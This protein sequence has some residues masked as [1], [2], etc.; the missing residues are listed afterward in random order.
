MRRDTGHELSSKERRDALSSG[1]KLEWWTIGAMATIVVAMYL[2][3]GSSQAMKA[4]WVEDL[5]GFVPPIAFLIANRYAQRDPNERF[6]YGYHRVIDI[7]FL[8][9]AVALTALG[10]YIFIDSVLGLIK[11]EHPTIGT[12]VIFGHQFWSGWL[13]IAVLVYSIIPPVILGRLKMRPARKI[14]DKT[15]K[16][17][18]DMNKADC[19]TGLAGIAGIIGIGV[20]WWWA[21]SVAAAVI[22]IDV[23]KDGVRNLKRVVSDVM[24][25]RPTTVDGE[26]SD[27]PDRVRD[28]LLELPW[29]ADAM[30]RL[31]EEGHIF[32]GE[33]FLD[34]CDDTDLPRRLD[35]A[36]HV[37]ESVHWSLQDIV[38]TIGSPPATIR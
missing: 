26:V 5:L 36:R 30:P 25:Q 14:H 33:V 3:M 20:G 28:A 17:D 6:P 24:D 2:V 10:L 19:M 15:L 31:R 23:I 1:R 34:V 8:A 35:Y 38:V 37:A 12:R 13:M 9:G 4:A 22:S 18:A 29:V 7:A 16:A 21:D 11:A 32:V 27:V